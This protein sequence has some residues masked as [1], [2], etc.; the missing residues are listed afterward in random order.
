[1]L[2]VETPYRA[3]VTYSLIHVIVWLCFLF[4]ICW[5]VHL[6]LNKISS[7]RMQILA[8]LTLIT[9]LLLTDV[10][11]IYATLTQPK[12]EATS[13]ISEIGSLPLEE[14]V[15][16]IRGFIDRRVKPSYRQPEAA[17]ELDNSLRGLFVIDYY[18][19]YLAG[20][21]EAHVILYQ[22]FGSCGQYAILMRYFLSMLGYETRLAR[23]KGRDHE[24]AEAEVNGSWYIV[25][26]WYIELCS[27]KRLTPIGE[28][29]SLEEFKNAQGVIVYY[30]NGTEIDA[31][32]EHGYFQN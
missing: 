21:D 10:V 1:M 5:L 9:T 11:T 16:R 31:G 18:L 17:L 30:L 27:G 6:S 24:W 22:G 28:L 26:P 4:A 3:L 13:F 7:R 19:V 8:I 12:K 23:F 25:D 15:Y 2:I 14:A 29:G 32:Y 20:F